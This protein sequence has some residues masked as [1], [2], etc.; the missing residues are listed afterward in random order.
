MTFVGN[1]YGV[2]GDLIIE[3]NR[4]PSDDDLWE[5]IGFCRRYGINMAQLAKFETVRNSIW[6]HDPEKFWHAEIFGR[7]GP[8]NGS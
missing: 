6:M 3:F 5:I 4:L 1:Y 2:V 7:D 8:G